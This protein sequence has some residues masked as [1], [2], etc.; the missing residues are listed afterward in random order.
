[1]NDIASAAP[2]EATLSDFRGG[3][4]ANTEFKLRGINHL[5]LVCRDMARTIDFYRR[6]LVAMEAPTAQRSGY[7]AAK[8]HVPKP[9][10][11]RPVKQIR[12]G[13]IL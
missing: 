7:L 4:P 13:S 9:P 11:D 3:R 10:I 12:L 1:M 6:I 8:L 2:G 5:A